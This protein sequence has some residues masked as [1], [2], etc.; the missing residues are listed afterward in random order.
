M[1]LIDDPVGVLG[2]TADEFLSPIKA[3]FAK[4]PDYRGPDFPEGFW[5]TEYENGEAKETITLVGHMMPHQ[6]FTQSKTQNAKI[7]HYPGNPEPAVQLLGGRFEP[8]T[9]KGE[10]KAKKFS[11]DD[12][13]MRAVP[14]ALQQYFDTLCE[15]GNVLQLQMGAWERW[16][17]LTSAIFNMNTLANIGYELKFEITGRQMPENCKL[18]AD[19]PPE[20]ES[21]LLEL[22]NQAAEWETEL[23]N[24]PKTFPGT[25]WDEIN[26]GIGTV[27]TGLAVVTKF[28]DGAFKQAEN[29]KA[30][31]SKAIGLV[32]YAKAKISAW[33]NQ[34]GSLNAY[35]ENPT[36][37]L[38]DTPFATSQM[39]NQAYVQKCCM[40]T[41]KPVQL[42]QEMK[43]ASNPS[44]GKY[45]STPSM[46]QKAQAM[47]KSPSIDKILANME[48]KFKAMAQYKPLGKHFVKQG[49]TLQ[50]I[51]VKFYGTADNWQKIMEH[52][53]LTTTALTQ[54]AI[55]EIPN[56]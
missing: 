29:A 41:A 6:P 14:D 18:V 43:E 1:G 11:I 23:Q 5:I 3:L 22:I 45:S 52:N 12:E 27:A 42:S 37:G 44:Y 56:L 38:N 53:K 4:V 55:L 33:K 48:A 16:G 46:A 7:E 13:E 17:F 31:A 10:W 39:M 28:V 15:R 51:S 9:I 34:M 8:L 35:F 24:K 36:Q 26:K 32:K 2:A 21:D 47:Q 20:V 49:D 19:A 30:A 50:K 40:S 54:G 25:L